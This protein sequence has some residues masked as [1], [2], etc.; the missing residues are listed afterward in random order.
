MKAIMLVVKFQCY[1]DILTLKLAN[2]KSKKSYRYIIL[3]NFT[4]FN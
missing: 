1:I 3:R 4:F 2:A